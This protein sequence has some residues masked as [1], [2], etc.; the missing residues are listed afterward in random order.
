MDGASSTIVQQPRQTEQHSG[1]SP[2]ALTAHMLTHTH[3]VSTMMTRLC[4]SSDRARLTSLIAVVLPTPGLRNRKDQQFLSNLPKAFFPAQ[5]TACDEDL[6]VCASRF[7]MRR[8]R[9]LAREAASEEVDGLQAVCKRC[10]K[11]HCLDR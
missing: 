2:C 3:L 6:Q 7:V 10:A 4:K 5:S 11:M 9:R 1:R 8:M